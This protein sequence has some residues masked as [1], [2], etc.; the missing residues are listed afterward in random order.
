MG[1]TRAEDS[2]SRLVEF[3]LGRTRDDR[4][5]LIY[6]ILMFDDHQL[7][8]THDYIQWLFPLDTPS[9]FNLTAPILTQ[10]D[11]AEFR[12]NERENK[13]CIRQSEDWAERSRRWLEPYNHNHLR[14]TRILKSMSLAGL[15][16][17]AREFYCALEAVYKHGPAGHIRARTFQFWSQAVQQ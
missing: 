12:D 3:Y 5:R 1:N 9:A 16:E 7:E 2:R 10:Q 14:I 11:I 8:H 13:L 17:Y 6:D 15:S 4:G